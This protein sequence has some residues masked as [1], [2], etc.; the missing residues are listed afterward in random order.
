MPSFTFL[1]IKAILNDSCRDDV[2]PN[3]VSHKFTVSHDTYE[4]LR[5]VFHKAMV[6][7]FAMQGIVY[8]KDQSKVNDLNNLV[9]LPMHRIARLECE[10][11][12]ITGEYEIS[13]ESKPS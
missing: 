1:H 9:F 8:L 10:T 7:I 11:K 4:Q 6:E 2:E 13:P 12:I 3:F 5:E